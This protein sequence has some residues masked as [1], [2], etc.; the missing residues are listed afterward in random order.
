MERQKG[1]KA[2]PESVSGGDG[3]DGS[4]STGASCE[5]GGTD[6]G[7][8]YLM[9]IR[10]AAKLSGLSES[11]IRALCKSS[12]PPPGIKVGRNYKV[13]RSSFFDYISRL[14]EEHA[15]VQSK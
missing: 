3:A 1:R 14:S 2:R 5:G 12:D 8:P 7:A 10:E 15:E 13:L 9:G 6:D 4:G 11:A